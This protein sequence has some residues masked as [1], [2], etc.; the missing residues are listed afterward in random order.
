MGGTKNVA[1]KA[2]APAGRAY[3]ERLKASRELY[4]EVQRE[5]K[6]HDDANTVL[7]KKAQ[8]LMTAT[9]L[10]AAVFAALASGT[11]ANWP[12][13]GP[14]LLGSTVIFIMGVVITFVLCILVNFS[15]RQP[16]PISG[17]K[18]L[19]HGELDDKAYT[20]VV[21]DGEEEYYKS[22]IEEYSLAL[23][24]QERINKI[25]AKLLK[26]AYIV[27]AT[28]VVFAIPGLVFGHV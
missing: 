19:C 11:T 22:R 14:V 16:V 7:D 12:Q 6:F 8:S 20:E 23:T 9:A 2:K 10:V 28:Y 15:R 26:W 3:K 1:G 24:K 5:F 18:L 21:S 17:E 27:F 25:K 13:W 4:N